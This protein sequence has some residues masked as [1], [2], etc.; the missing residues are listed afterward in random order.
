MSEGRRESVRKVR[1]VKS[2]CCNMKMKLRG[3]ILWSAVLTRKMFLLREESMNGSCN[4]LLCSVFRQC[5]V[6]NINKKGG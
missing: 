4:E 3:V 5:Y 1:W 2:M 6:E